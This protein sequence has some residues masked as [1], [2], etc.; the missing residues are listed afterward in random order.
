MFNIMLSALNV[1]ALFGT[2]NKQNALVGAVPVI[3]KNDGLFAAVVN[4]FIR[5]PQHLASWSRRSAN[6]GTTFLE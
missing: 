2:F 5:N 1:K 4:I 6:P 3:V